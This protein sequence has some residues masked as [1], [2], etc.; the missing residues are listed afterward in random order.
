MRLHAAQVD[1]LTSTTLAA[2]QLVFP[3]VGGQLAYSQWPLSIY[4]T[5]EPLTWLVPNGPETEGNGEDYALGETGAP[6][7]TVAG[8]TTASSITLPC[9][10][11]G[12][13]VSVQLADTQ[14][15]GG[16]PAG[17]L[18]LCAVNV[19]GAATDAASPAAALASLGALPSVAYQGATSASSTASGSSASAPVRFQYG[20]SISWA[21]DCAA[22]AGAGFASSGEEA[23]PWWQVQLSSSGEVLVSTVVVYLSAAAPH[24]GLTPLA[25]YLAG[26]SVTGSSGSSALS[27]EPCFTEAGY[28]TQAIVASCYGARRAA[29]RGR[30]AP[31]AG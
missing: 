26:S 2:V 20:S 23:W 12:R 9:A 3:N 8:A 25:V 16:N 14:Y 6:C 28:G 29:P 27:Y 30:D 21:T 11:Y 10:G 1:L 31:G 13:Y 7:A 17:A 24:L 15:A 19:F 18:S 4:V 22:G 5:N